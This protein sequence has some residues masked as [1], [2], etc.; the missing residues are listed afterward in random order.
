MRNELSSFEGGLIFIDTNISLDYSCLR[1][2]GVYDKL[3]SKGNV[4]FIIGQIR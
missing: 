3:S 2:L 1:S 4:Y